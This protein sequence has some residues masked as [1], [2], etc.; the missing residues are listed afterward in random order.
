VRSESTPRRRRRGEGPSIAP[1]VLA[2]L[3]LL[4]APLRVDARPTE[5][6]PTTEAPTPA[7]QRALEATLALAPDAP[8]SPDDVFVAP[9]EAREVEAEAAAALARAELA[10]GQARL[11]ADGRRAA[12]EAASA[13]EERARTTR[14]R[15]RRLLARAEDRLSEL[16]V[17]AYVTGTD[18]EMRSLGA[19]LDGD[20]TDEAGGTM[21]LFSEMLR[22]QEAAVERAG[23]RLRRSN[24]GLR[25]ATEAL[26]RRE[27]EAADAALRR[28][29][30]ERALAAVRD[31][32][33]AAVADV[34]AADAALRRAPRGVPV[35]LDTPLI[36]LAR[37]SAEDLSSWFEARGF[38]S[39]I[40]TP[41]ADIARWFIE[42]GDRE[43]IRGD[44]AFAQ[45]VL[46]TGGFANRDSVE[47]NNYSGIGH[48]DTCPAGWTFPSP[49][50]GVRAQIQLLKSYAVRTPTY[51][52]PL[53][54]RRLRGPAGCCATWNE[55]TK[56]WATA[57]GYGP[58]VLGLYSSIVDHALARRAAGIGL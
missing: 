21:I 37:L 52:Q 35:P 18:F 56:R 39:R 53:V 8:R 47:A 22:H 3:L 2:A 7:E 33:R 15:N 43:G 25:A 49:R 5:P 32:H 24:Q 38:R 30:R 46:E 11:E 50:D 13:D 19:L 44:I 1:A 17:S 26:R 58:I 14:D 48:C 31:E 27:A 54:D 51:A 12:A 6:T 20:T 45:A 29:T 36:G 10:M 57:D 4:L 40:P 28:T 55:L 42:E 9:V 41:I 16:A 34:A 23:A